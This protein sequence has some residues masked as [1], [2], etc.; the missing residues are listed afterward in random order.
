[1]LRARARVIAAQAHLWADA[2]RTLPKKF[3]ITKTHEVAGKCLARDRQTQLR[4]NAGRFA[5]GER[6]SRNF[7]L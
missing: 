5:A 6:D 7:R 1:V 3:D 4:T 2:L